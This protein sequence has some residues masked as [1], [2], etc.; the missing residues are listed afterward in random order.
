M[1]KNHYVTSEE[2]RAELQI[3]HLKGQIT[4]N[5]IKIFTTMI[6]HIQRPFPYPRDADR[7]DVRSFALEKIIGKWH[8]CDITR[9]N[10]FSYFTQVIKNDLYAGWNKLQKG[11]ADFSYSN[12]FDTGI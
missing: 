7:Q 5:M 9:P 2:I 6:D 10:L 3:C 11:S 1:S 12:I 8:K 4:N